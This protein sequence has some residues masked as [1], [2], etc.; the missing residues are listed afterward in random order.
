MKVKLEARTAF[1]KSIF[2]TILKFRRQHAA[3]STLTTLLYTKRS[4]NDKTSIATVTT[5]AA[6]LV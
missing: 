5:A 2:D 4:M 3:A 1:E 6:K